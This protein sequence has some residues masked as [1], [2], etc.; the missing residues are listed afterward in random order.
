MM[1]RRRIIPVMYTG[2]NEE[3]YLDRLYKTGVFWAKQGD[4]QFLSRDES[5]KMLRH[6]DLFRVPNEDEMK[7]RAENA[8]DPVADAVENV[9]AAREEEAEKISK[10]KAAKLD[11][12]DALKKEI[13]TITDKEE[14]LSFAARQPEIAGMSLDRRKTVENL[15]AE[16]IET[17]TLSGTLL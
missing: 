12:S 16:I 14:L 15:K 17:M 5:M 11:L 9:V 1:D 13:S 10:T 8:G 2:D 6:I 4:I 7:A 3:G